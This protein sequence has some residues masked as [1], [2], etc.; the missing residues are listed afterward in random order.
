LMFSLC[1]TVRQLSIADSR[2]RPMRQM[3]CY[4]VV[5]LPRGPLLPQCS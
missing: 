4:G 3:A 5:N 2:A 1:V